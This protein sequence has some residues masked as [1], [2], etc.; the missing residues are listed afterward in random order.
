MIDLRRTTWVLTLFTAIPSAG[1]A[2]PRDVDL[3]KMQDWDIVVAEPVPDSKFHAAQEFQGTSPRPPASHASSVLYF[4][5]RLTAPTTGKG[6][7]RGELRP[8]LM[9]DNHARCG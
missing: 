6:A 5:Y 3:A 4:P 9:S 2:A 1:A 7:R 8:C